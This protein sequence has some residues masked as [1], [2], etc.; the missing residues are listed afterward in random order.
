MK[1]KWITPEDHESIRNRQTQSTLTLRRQH[2]SSVTFKQ[3]QEYQHVDRRSPFR[4]FHRSPERGSFRTPCQPCKPHSRARRTDGGRLSR[5]RPDRAFHS[6]RRH[7]R[8]PHAASRSG[9]SPGCCPATRRRLPTRPPLPTPASILTDSSF[10]FPLR[11][12]RP[13]GARNRPPPAEKPRPSSS[14]SI[15]SFTGRTVRP[16]QG[17][18]WPRTRRARRS[19]SSAPRAWPARRPLPNS[20]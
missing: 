13:S 16:S 4:L 7:R 5:E 11:L 10:P 8:G 14:G 15:R 1:Y 9:T 17:S 6:A 2:R 18:T 3:I 20:V 12:K 19:S